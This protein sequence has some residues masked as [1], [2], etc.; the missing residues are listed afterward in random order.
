M[1]TGA[2]IIA[3]RYTDVASRFQREGKRSPSDKRGGEREGERE[4]I[5]GRGRDKR[6]DTYNATQEEGSG[7][8]DGGGRG[9]RGARSR[10]R[11]CGKE[12]RVKEGSESETPRVTDA[13]E[14]LE[15]DGDIREQH[16]E[17]LRLIGRANWLN[18]LVFGAVQ[19][20][21][22]PREMLSMNPSG[23]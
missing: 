23:R 21:T 22:P 2:R 16:D 19:R 7:N 15:R 13:I 10:E 6:R 5:G 8:G 12:K 3:Q 17:L 20:H 14:R 18:W 9:G 11:R 1:H 4:D